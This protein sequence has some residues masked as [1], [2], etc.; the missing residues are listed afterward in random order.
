MAPTLSHVVAR[1][2]SNSNSIASTIGVAQ[3][4]QADR[5]AWSVPS[6]QPPTGPTK[7]GSIYSLVAEKAATEQTSTCRRTFHAPTLSPNTSAHDA[8]TRE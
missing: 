5:H 1:S 8:P 6:Y 4:Q 2:K 3:S 7:D